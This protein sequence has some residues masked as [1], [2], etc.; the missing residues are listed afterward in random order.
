M[1]HSAFQT[2]TRSETN[3]ASL[4]SISVIKRFDLKN[5]GFRYVYLQIKLTVNL[6]VDEKKFF[7][8]VRDKKKM[9]TAVKLILVMKVDRGYG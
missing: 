3:Q 4:I 2:V 8:N 7:F 5:C 9:T 6:T 1:I